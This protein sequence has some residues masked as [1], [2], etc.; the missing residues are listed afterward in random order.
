MKR[1]SISLLG[2]WLAALAFAHLH[3]VFAGDL[4]VGYTILHRA[5]LGGGVSGLLQLSVGNDELSEVRNVDLRIAPGTVAIGGNGVVQVGT[6][7]AGEMRHA[8]VTFLSTAN[9]PEERAAIEVRVD[10]DMA[11][12]HETYHVMAHAQ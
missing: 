9:F 3:P 11:G 2:I 4:R 12:V 5:A 8:I 10:L 7:P 1:V 6:V